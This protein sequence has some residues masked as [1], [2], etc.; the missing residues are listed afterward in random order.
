MLAP[1]AAAVEEPF[2]PQ[3]LPEAEAVLDGR[4]VTVES[5]SVIIQNHKRPS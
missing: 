4:R 3:L 2:A 5:S 1:R